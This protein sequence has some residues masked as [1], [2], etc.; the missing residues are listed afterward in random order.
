[1]TDASNSEQDSASP[2]VFLT[3]GVTPTELSAVSAVLRGLL[4]EESDSLRA[5][6][7]LTQDAWRHSQ[8][9]VRQPLTPGA[10]QW[11]SFSG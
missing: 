9:N 11:R 1:M 10:G 6:P 2:L 4:Q 7:T 3:R 5:K 8:R